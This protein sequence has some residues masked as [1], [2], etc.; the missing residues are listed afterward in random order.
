MSNIERRAILEV[1][2]TLVGS[3]IS[4]V[5]IQQEVV[6]KL[7]EIL[8]VRRCAIFKIDRG[9]ADKTYI[10]ITAGVPT[11]EHGI[12]L[13]EEISK[14][15]DIEEAVKGKKVMVIS[16]P[17]NSP[18]TSY[19]R[20]IVEK[21][22][23]NQI[24]YLPLISELTNKV[25]GVIVI[26]AVKEKTQFDPEEIEFCSQVGE[27]ISL[28]VDR[29]EILIEQMRDLIINRITALGGFAKRLNKLTQEFS[30]DVKII[31]EEIEKLEKICPKGSLLMK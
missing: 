4:K 21:K 13:R 1:A 12:G 18:L 29:E 24:L 5:P 27:L 6:Q 3:I 9:E 26:D 16:D 15:P 14:H 10:E 8:G 28:I 17:K 11:E 22:E 30:R 25:I 31:L 20:E 19:F 2:K 23:I 7:S